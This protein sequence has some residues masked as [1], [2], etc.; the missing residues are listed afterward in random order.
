MVQTYD[1]SLENTNVLTEFDDGKIYRYL[2]DLE[3]NICRRG[4]LSLYYVQCRHSVSTVK[5]KRP[6]I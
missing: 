1:L 3:I 6:S 2:L 5:F 4:R